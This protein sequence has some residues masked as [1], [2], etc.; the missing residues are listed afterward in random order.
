MT[1]Q[2]TETNCRQ[3]PSWMVLI[4]GLI[5]VV[6]MAGAHQEE[7][8]NVLKAISASFDFFFL[9]YLCEL[10]WAVG[11]TSHSTKCMVP[12]CDG[13]HNCLTLIRSWVQAL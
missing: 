12:Q 6:G 4:N 3:A 9:A 10:V 13:Y 11:C 1:L 7:E 2:F 8:E 5:L